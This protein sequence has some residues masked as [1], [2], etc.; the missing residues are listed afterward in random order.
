MKKFQIV[1]SAKPFIND[2]NGVNAFIKA[3][4]RICIIPRC[5]RFDKL[6]DEH[7]NSVYDVFVLD[8]EE[9]LPLARKIMKKVFGFEESV[10]DGVITLM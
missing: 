2:A 6:V 5:W 1:L 3:V 4:E 9:K 8:C 10:I 7:G